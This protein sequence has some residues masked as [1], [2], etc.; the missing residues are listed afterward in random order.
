MEAVTLQAE[1]FQRDSIFEV[2]T[3]LNWICIANPAN[4]DSTSSK[5]FSKCP[6][7]SIILL[8]NPPKAINKDIFV[9]VNVLMMSNKEKMMKILMLLM[10]M[11]MITSGEELI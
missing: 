2:Y 9:E 6:F 4:A 5:L 8:E 10:I 1:T 11:K 3:S 7:A